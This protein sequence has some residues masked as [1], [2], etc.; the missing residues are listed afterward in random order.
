MRYSIL[1]FTFYLLNPFSSI[2]A[3][4]N[5][6]IVL[7]HGFIG[8]GPEEMGGYN[9]WGG[10]YDYVEYLDSLGYEVYNVSVGPISSNWDC[11][12]EAYYKIKGGQVDYGKRHSTQYGIIQKPSSKKWPGLYPEWDADHPIHIIGHSMGGQTARR[13][14]Y[15]LETEI[16]V[17]SARII[18]ESSDLLGQNH[19]NWIRS[20]TTMSS[21]HNGTTLS[22]IITKSV[23]FLQDF[24][25]LAA[26]IGNRFYS[27]DLEQW[28][29][30]KNSEESLSRYFTRIR[31]HPAWATNNFSSWDM[32][33]EGA[34]QLNTVAVANK[35]I[36]YFSFATSNT[37]LAPLSGKHVPNHDMSLIL[38]PNARAMGKQIDYWADSTS[39]DSTWFENDGIVN[40]ISMIGPTTGLNGSDPI[41]EYQVNKVFVPGS[42]YYMG[43]LTMDH[44]TLMGHGDISNEVLNNILLLFKEHADRLYALPPIINIY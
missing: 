9:Y 43:K 28:G 27:F 11:A 36:F 35:N 37:H 23:P 16:Y 7:I 39:T 17:D 29:F 32:S 4:N 31:N 2:K 13:L 21:P 6:P 12:V 15:L 18:P 40:T 3:N 19:Q 1:I 22:D 34:R 33:L 10:N 25:G 14:Q 20:I 42:W 30:K 38:R 5:Y 26:V 24:I 44:R 8:W 41:I